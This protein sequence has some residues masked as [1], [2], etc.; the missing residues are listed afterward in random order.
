MRAC[1]V[2]FALLAFAPGAVPAQSAMAVEFYHLDGQGNVL[3]VTDWSGQVVESH[4]YDV[5][6][7]E[8]NPQAGTQA[9]QP[10]RFAGKERDTETGWDYFG[11]RYDGSKIGRFTTVDPASTIKENVLDP[12]RWNRYA[13]ARNNPLRYVDPDG[14]DWIEYTG[15]K[16][17]WY[18]GSIGDHSAPSETPSR[19]ADTTWQIVLR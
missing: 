8:E 15:Q 1:L 10:K 4:D 9:P 11:A 7:Q 3:A 5:F 17:T 12:Q 16:L 2:A 18:G 13:Y 19:F 6:G 14:Q